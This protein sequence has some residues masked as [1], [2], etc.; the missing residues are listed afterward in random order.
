MKIKIIHIPLVVV[1]VF[2]LNVSL[3]AQAVPR[4]Q[5]LQ[6]LP[7]EYP[8]IIEQTQASVDLMIYGD[9]SDSHYLDENPLNGIDDRR[10]K[11]FEQMAIRF[12][13]FLVQ[14]S[15][16]APIDFKV[17]MKQ[18][19]AFPLYI[20]T[21]NIATSKPELVNTD[22]INFSTLGESD[23][24]S[25]QMISGGM[26]DSS[27]LGFYRRIN[28]DDYKLL[29]LIEEFY[30]HNPQADIYHR[31]KQ[32]PDRELFKVMYFDLPGEDP[33]TWRQEYEN[34]FSKLLPDKY[35]N[36]LKAYVHPFIVDQST[37][38]TKTFLGYEFIIQYW[39][40]YPF[41]DGGN[42]HEGDWEHINVVICPKNKVENYL[43][44]DD[45]QNILHGAWL[46]KE[47][48]AEEL[49]IKRIENY[50][51][52]FVMP[53]DF[54]RPNVYQ[55]K[56]AWQR[57]MNERI[58]Q[59]FGENDLLKKIRYRAYIDD[60]ETQINTHPFIYI[61]GDNKG[62]DQIMQMPGGTNRD[63]HGSYPFS[64][65]LKISERLVRPSRFLSI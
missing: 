63:S 40:Y 59:R 34:N 21:W 39:F 51:H 60:A 17:F 48:T 20:D 16:I 12:A 5:Y 24:Q 64:V 65:C 32:H 14:N 11:I 62:L 54:S 22:L 33:A 8:R 49:V 55:S 23:C 61:G 50:F 44:A 30:P 57:E 46:D 13:P 52:H 2:L 42:N 45:V 10:D 28:N 15:T 19:S 36:F 29:A 27:E 31:A 9:Q 26:L 53:L 41:N 47:G 56:E 37:K 43:T 6:Y 35:H 25:D 18:N 1:G 4:D 38:T 7:L 3:F 58:E